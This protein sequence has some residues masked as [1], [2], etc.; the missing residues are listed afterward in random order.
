MTTNISIRN[1][2]DNKQT[3]LECIPSSTCWRTLGVLLS[4]EGHGCTQSIFLLQRA[5]EFLGKFRNT[6]IS[7][8][9]RWLAI[10]TVIEPAVLYPLLNT[11][12]SH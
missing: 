7:P 2:A 5:K 12:Y 4:P 6:N 8:R 9:A 3:P 11:S 10:T 1:P